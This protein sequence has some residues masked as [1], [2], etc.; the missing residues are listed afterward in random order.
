MI[1]RRDVAAADAIEAERRGEVS[2]AVDRKNA[3]DAGA[4]I[5]ETDQ[6]A[7]DQ[8]AALH[9]D[10]DG[11]IGAGELARRNDFLDQGVDG[12]P[13]HGGAD[14]SDERH[15]VKMPELEMPAP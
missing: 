6:G 5:E 3:R 4:V 14:A 8:H 13:V 12:G 9:A 11:G 7:G 15:G 10:E 2:Q 1:A